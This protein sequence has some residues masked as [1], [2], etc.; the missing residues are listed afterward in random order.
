M[1][2]FQ[3][4]DEL[5]DNTEFLKELVDACNSWNGSLE[6]L[7]V[8]EFDEEFFENFFQDKMEVARATFFGSIGNWNDDYI[9]FD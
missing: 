5:K 7:Q 8:Y 6:S 1:T 3:I 9:R 4:G 2:K